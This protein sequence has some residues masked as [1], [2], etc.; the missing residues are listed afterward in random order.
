M[1]V[2][3]VAL[4]TVSCEVAIVGGGPAGL[5]AA[6]VLARRGLRVDLFDAMP[7][8][9]RKFLLAGKGGLNL[10]HSEDFVPFVGRYGAASA[11]LQSHLRYF[12]ATPLR[13]WAAELGIDTFVG[14]SGRVF[15]REMKAAPLLR[16][17][18]QRL[19]ALGVRIHTRHRIVGFV[20]APATRLGM[21]SATAATGTASPASRHPPALRVST[22]TG[23]L[24]VT[25]EA[26]LL[27]LG[28]ASWPSLGSD[29][30]WLHWLRDAGVDIATLQPAN[31]GFDVARCSAEGVIVPGWTEH[32]RSRF[33]G[34]PLKGACLHWTQPDGRAAEQI[35][36][37]VITETGVE[38]SLIYAAS[39]GIREAIASQGR[40]VVMLDLL[41]QRSADSVAH[42]LA[43]PRGS[44]S[45]TTYLKARLGLEGL[46]TALMYEL[47]PRELI[48]DPQRLAA[49]LKSLPLPLQAARP[50][51]EAISTAGG[52]RFAAMNERLML[53]ALPGV[54]CA[55]EMLD[56]E[57][58]TGGYLLTACFSTGVAA[59]GGIADFLRQARPCSA[60]SGTSIAAR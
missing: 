3:D 12:G 4:P 6:E 28:G 23:E 19:R 40:A 49:A 43:Q 21:A 26:V 18:L 20:P 7:S 57:A 38:G 52:V 22:P 10:T 5:M 31:C 37:F 8:V 48:A 2:A 32:F 45:L 30:A 1:Q 47:L 36:E 56:W 42:A 33:V 24:V 25:A 17:W 27:A 54:F 51:A 58:P 35:G 41:A 59:A 15:P 13:A 50:L 11:L 46:R 29:G 44:R 55:G 39:A 60:A 16:R 14:S 34:V 9:G 53:Q